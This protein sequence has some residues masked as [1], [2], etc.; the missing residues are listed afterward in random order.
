MLVYQRV[1]RSFQLKLQYLWK[2]PGL[3]CSKW[4]PNYGDL[5]RW[6]W[7]GTTHMP[8]SVSKSNMPRR[9]WT[10]HARECLD[11][12][13]QSHQAPPT[14]VRWHLKGMVQGVVLRTF[15][16]PTSL[17]WHGNPGKL[18][19]EEETTPTSGWCRSQWFRL[20]P[21]WL[22]CAWVGWLG[23]HKKWWLTPW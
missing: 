20:T 12:V 2:M 4:C 19:G 22:L 17:A 21:W 18:P 1:S 10:G 13:G 5:W 11:G 8:T 6:C 15:S 23:T 9:P 16:H 7:N 14:Y 3:P